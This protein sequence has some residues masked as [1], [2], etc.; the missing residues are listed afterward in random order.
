MRIINGI[1]TYGIIRL[2]M[3]GAKLSAML[4]LALFLAGPVW[5]F[6]ILFLVATGIMKIL[7]YLIGF[8]VFFSLLAIIDAK[9][10]DKAL[11]NLIYVF[12]FIGGGFY[13]IITASNN[14]TI[15]QESF[16][17]KHVEEHLNWNSKPIFIKGFT[18]IAGGKCYLVNAMQDEHGNTTT[19]YTGPQWYVTLPSGVVYE[20]EI[21]EAECEIPSKNK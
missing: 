16:G 21:A 3:L 2:F 18:N 7:P 1:A 9:V 20:R 6:V 4:F 14:R 5:G 8:I 10:K 15:G 19:E 12:I 13:W 17:R 11:R